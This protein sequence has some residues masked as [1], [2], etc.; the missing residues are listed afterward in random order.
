MDFNSEKFLKVYKMK[1][2]IAD[3][4]NLDY[5][6]KWIM[7]ISS[8]T[9][10]SMTNEEKESYLEK[11][12][13]LK[14][15]VNISIKSQKILLEWFEKFVIE[16]EDYEFIYRA[17]PVELHSSKL[18][19]LENKY[20]NFHLIQKESVRQWIHVCEYNLTWFSTSIADVYF[21]N[22]PCAI[23]R[24]LVIPK[25]ADCELF[26][27]C[28]SITEYEEFLEFI[29]SKHQILFPIKK[30]KFLRYYGT[31]ECGTIYKRFCDQLEIILKND[32]TMPEV[33]LECNIRSR[34]CRI[35]ISFIFQLN[36]IIDMSSFLGISKNKFLKNQLKSKWMTQKSYSVYKKKMCN[37][38]KGIVN[39]V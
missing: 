1:K 25:E 6:K 15:F 14:G 17:H 21:Q 4:Y 8:F 18:F 12:P 33:N 16:N 30:D 2:E 29:K 35:S 10:P 39:N 20:Y 19:E 23:L 9:H 38:L 34:V 3:E 5:N 26:Y 31:F 7:F 22:K 28:E 27:D 13:F 11:F 32:E 37:M 24:P 36:K